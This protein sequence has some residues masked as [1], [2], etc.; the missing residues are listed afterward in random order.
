MVICLERGADLHIA[1]LML[2]PLPLTVSCF[3]KIQTNFTFL[4]PA[5]PGTPRQRATKR[6]CVCVLWLAWMSLEAFCSLASRRA[7]RTLA[8]ASRSS[9]VFTR[10]LFWS[11]R[12]LM[13]DRN[14][15]TRICQKYT[16]QHSWTVTMQRQH[17]EYVHFGPEQC[18]RTMDFAVK[19]KPTVICFRQSRWLIQ[20]VTTSETGY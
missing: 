8:S 13:Y 3:S 6:V 5:H 10:M 18:T 7:T 16:T 14:R 15:W 4:V 11:V 17:T 20:R 19:E 9:T 1:R 12:S 2:M